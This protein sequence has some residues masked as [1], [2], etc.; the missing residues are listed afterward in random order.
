MWDSDMIFLYHVQNLSPDGKERVKG[1]VK[2]FDETKGFGFITGD[3]DAKDYFVHFTAI[4]TQGFKTL[5]EGQ[6]VEFTPAFGDG[7]KLIALD[8]VV[9]SD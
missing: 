6:Q 4:K 7:G 2:W 9:I 3:H 8:V 5:S 1:T